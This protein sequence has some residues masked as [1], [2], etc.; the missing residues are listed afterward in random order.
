M[1]FNFLQLGHEGGNNSVKLAAIIALSFIIN[2]LLSSALNQ[3][4][5]FVNGADVLALLRERGNRRLGTGT[6]YSVLAFLV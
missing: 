2:I 6:S 3:F 5:L 4:L 1:L